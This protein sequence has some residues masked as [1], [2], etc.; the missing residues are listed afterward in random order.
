M[1]GDEV[2]QKGSNITAERLRFDFSF[3]RKVTDEELAEVE[4]LVNEAIAG[5]RCPWSAEEMTVAEARA[6]GAMGL[7]ES[8]VRRALCKRVHHGRVLQGNLLAARTAD[9]GDL[10]SFKIKLEEEAS[11]CRRAPHQGRPSAAKPN[12][13]QFIANRGGCAARPSPQFS[14]E[15]S[16]MDVTFVTPEGTFNYRVC[17]VIIHDDHLLAMQDGGFALLLTLPGG[18]VHLGETLESAMH[19]EM[20]EELRFRSYS[21]PA[22]AVRKLLC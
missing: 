18:R 21:P 22:V 3:G 20:R 10:V 5:Q 6:Q 12:N 1:L 2:H 19:R 4:R 8:Q 17:A 16:F 13:P 15:R 11:S 9:T 7:F 14:S